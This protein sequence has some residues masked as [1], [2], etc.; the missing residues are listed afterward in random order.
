MSPKVLPAVLAVVLGSA[1][2]SFGAGLIGRLE[3]AKRTVL[4]DEEWDGVRAGAFFF[5]GCLVDVIRGTPLANGETHWESALEDVRVRDLSD[6]RLGDCRI[7]TRYTVEVTAEQA[8]HFAEAEKKGGSFR[9]I[10]RP[11]PDPNP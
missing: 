5:P 3:T 11:M 4:I 2:T 8:A 6:C 10:L 1:G 9:L 7:L